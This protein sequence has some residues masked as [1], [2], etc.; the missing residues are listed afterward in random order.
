MTT[1]YGGALLT[2][3]DDLAQAVRQY[4]HTTFRTPGRAAVLRRWSYFW[5]LAG[6]VEPVCGRGLSRAC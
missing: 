4:R 2:N 3:R 1:L 5:L 6:T